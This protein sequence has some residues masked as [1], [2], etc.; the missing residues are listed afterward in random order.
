MVAPIGTDSD[1]PHYV[2][3]QT[4]ISADR[5][6]QTVRRV[7]DLSRRVLDTTQDFF[8]RRRGTGIAWAKVVTVNTDHFVVQPPGIPPPA[9]VQVWAFIGGTTRDL[10]RAI[11]GVGLD[12][13]VPYVMRVFGSDPAA[14]AFCLWPF[15]GTCD[16]SAGPGASIGGGSAPS[17]GQSAPALSIEQL[18]AQLN[19]GRPCGGCL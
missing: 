9:T 14:R 7:N 12:D 10:R 15:H 3:G 5:L 17:A 1:I 19:G 18:A 4:V 13:E 11:P 8:P 6:N 2:A 16:P